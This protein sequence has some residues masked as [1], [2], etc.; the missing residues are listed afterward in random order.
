MAFLSTAFACK[1]KAGDSA[2]SDIAT[3]NRVKTGM[4]TPENAIGFASQAGRPRSAAEIAKILGVDMVTFGGQEV[5]VVPTFEGDQILV[6]KQ[7]EARPIPVGGVAKS[8]QGFFLGANIAPLKN[9][10]GLVG[11]I[12]LRLNKATDPMKGTVSEGGNQTNMNVVVGVRN[13]LGQ[14]EDY[15]VSYLNQH[16]TLGSKPVR[17]LK[18][19]N[20]IV[21][22]RTG[23]TVLEFRERGNQVWRVYGVY[24]D[25]RMKHGSVV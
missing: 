7:G 14:T 1:P 2:L 12:Y 16:D 10:A 6:L 21:E 18:I 9:G 8:G 5:Y 23:E 20:S 25:P 19:G 3:A 13:A 17:L 11:S 15:L 22:S 4:Y 24:N